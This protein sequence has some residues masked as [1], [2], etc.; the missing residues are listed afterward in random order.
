[1]SEAN[2]VV[3][4]GRTAPRIEPAEFAAAIG[5]KPGSEISGGTLDPIALSHIGNEL[6]KRLRSTGGRP[7]LE[8]ATQKCKLPL[9]ASDVAALEQIVDSI[10][11]TTGSRP[12]IGQIASV[13]IRFCL[14]NSRTTPIANHGNPGRG[15]S[16]MISQPTA[17]DQGGEG[18]FDRDS[19]MNR[20]VPQDRWCAQRALSHAMSLT[21]KL[22]GELDAARAQ[23]AMLKPA[24]DGRMIVCPQGCLTL[25]NAVRSAFVELRGIQPFKEE[26]PDEG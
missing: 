11:K 18:A 24:Q 20:I 21:I 25:D 4:T 8:D 16:E 5:A 17:D 9:S 2:R 23:L 19:N 26:V 14:N 10:E 7:A 13:L 12:S 22:L 3:D 1:M 6:I 15:G